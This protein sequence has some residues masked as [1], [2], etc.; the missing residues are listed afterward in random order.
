MKASPNFRARHAA[1]EDEVWSLYPECSRS[2]EPLGF[3]TVRERAA[4]ALGASELAL[5]ETTGI[6]DSQ[7]TQ[8]KTGTWLDEFGTGLGRAALACGLLPPP[9]PAI[10]AA[11]DFIAG[12]RKGSGYGAGDRFSRMR[13]VVRTPP[14]MRSIALHLTVTKLAASAAFP[15]LIIERRPVVLGNSGKAARVFSK[16]AERLSDDSWEEVGR[17]ERFDRSTAEASNGERIVFKRV[18]VIQLNDALRV[19][20]VDAIRP[21]A[22]DAPLSTMR[23]LAWAEFSAVETTQTWRPSHGAAVASHGT[24]EVE[25]TNR[26]MQPGGSLAVTSHASSMPPSLASHAACSYAFY[27][28]PLP[29]EATAL[30]LS[31]DDDESG[32]ADAQPA[33]LNEIVALEVT[34]ESPFLM[35][36]P[37]QLLPTFIARL[38]RRADHCRTLLTAARAKSGATG[39]GQSSLWKMVERLNTRAA[40]LTAALDHITAERNRGVAFKA[41]TRKTEQAL[42]YVATNLHTQMLFPTDNNDSTVGGGQDRLPWRYRS[43][44]CAALTVTVGAAAAHCMGFKGGGCRRLAERL[45]SE[46]D[47]MSLDA[48]SEVSLEL[49]QRRDVVFSQMLTAALTAFVNLVVV[50]WQDARWWATI[51]G[52]GWLLV[53][54]SLLSTQ[55]AELGMVDDYAEAA[56]LIEGVVLRIAPAAPPNPVD[57]PLGSP[58]LSTVRGSLRPGSIATRAST[59]STESTFTLPEP[60]IDGV[61]ISIEKLHQGPAQEN[62]CVYEIVLH[63]TPRAPLLVAPVPLAYLPSPCQKPPFTVLLSPLQVRI[64]CDNLHGHV[65]PAAQPAAASARRRRHCDQHRFLHAGH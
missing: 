12:V 32:G 53:L 64:C 9:G 51:A 52:R 37:M 8:L 40:D 27:R 45:M 22:L 3:A 50:R 42:Q 23:S 43:I 2:P 25:L 48:F 46:C 7:L 33:K 24:L 63:P 47:Q 1:L 59:S 13:S 44:K 4:R 11:D 65:L 16:D 30:D 29:A 18:F 6:L 41:S 14:W 10:V 49:E 61:S 58:R 55:G 56:S 39:E 54:E 19:N 28:F 35:D 60:T 21:D 17:T 20:I 38:Q 15:M 36:V 31:L 57:P 5:A 26:A 62:P 34:V